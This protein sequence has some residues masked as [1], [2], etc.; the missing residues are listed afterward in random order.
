[1]KSRI[2]F[3]TWNDVVSSTNHTLGYQKFGDLQIETKNEQSL[4]VGLST[5]LTDLSIVSS[6]GGFVDTNCVFDF[7]IARENNLNFDVENGLYP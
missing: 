4:N 5:D 7:D 1:M 6:L 2:P 3:D